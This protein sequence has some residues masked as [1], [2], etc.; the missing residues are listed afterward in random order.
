MT[1]GGYTLVWS[2][3]E[4]TDYTGGNTIYGT[5]NSMTLAGASSLKNDYPQNP[6][7]TE[8]GTINY[9]NYRLALATRTNIRNTNPG[10]Y[11]VRIT[12]NPTNMQDAWGLNNYFSSKPS[13]AA[14]D[15]FSGGTSSTCTETQVPTTG[16]LFGY[17][18]TNGLTTATGTYNGT[19]TGNV[20]PYTTDTT[21]GAHW[22]AGGRM[23]GTF[24][25]PDGVTNINSNI[26]NNL[27]GY[28]GETQANHHFG[29][30]GG[31]SASDTSFATTTTCTGS[32]L[33]P[34]SFNGGEGRY[35]QWFVK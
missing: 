31:T 9:T 21:Y 29:K 35:L 5:A 13:T 25:S 17:T 11:R 7:T 4:K 12:E 15:Y 14:F 26:H 18:Y 19:T 28:F 6:V 16:K 34:H 3:S 22:D 33:V 8:N 20:C 27:F 10:E 1:N 24:L 30:C 2:Y 32:S 23:N